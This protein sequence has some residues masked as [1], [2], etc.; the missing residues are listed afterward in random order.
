MEILSKNLGAGTSE[1]TRKGDAIHVVVKLDTGEV[2]VTWD[3]P[4]ED[5]IRFATQILEAC[6]APMSNPPGV[7]HWLIDY[8]A[9]GYDEPREE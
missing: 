2:A 6:K 9:G 8:Y 3:M 1:V 5:A 7:T 4:P